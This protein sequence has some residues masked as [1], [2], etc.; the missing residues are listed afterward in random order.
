MSWL[1]PTFARFASRCFAS[2]GVSFGIDTAT[3]VTISVFGSFG[4]KASGYPR[5]TCRFTHSPG[6]IFWNMDTTSEWVNPN[7]R[8]SLT[9]T[10]TSPIKKDYIQPRVTARITELRILNIRHTLSS[11]P[12]IWKIFTSFDAQVHSTFV[13][14]LWASCNAGIVWMTVNAMLWQTRIK[15][16]TVSIIVIQLVLPVA[17]TPFWAAGPFGTTFFTCRNSSSRSS[18]PTMVKPKPRGDFTRVVS[19]CSPHNSD[20]SFV[21]NGLLICW[22]TANSQCHLMVIVLIEIS[23]LVIKHGLLFSQA[24]SA[25]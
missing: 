8:L 7:T 2:A 1:V 11:T 4:S 3:V 15:I 20:G 18:P 14:A 9:R 24:I 21:K 12:V 5:H 16:R 23:H 25:K 22:L 17:K 13:R 6:L 19:R 10:R